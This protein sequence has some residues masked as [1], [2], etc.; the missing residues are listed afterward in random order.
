MSARIRI[1]VGFDGSADSWA[2]ARFA[3]A[4]AAA[5]HGTVRLVHSLLDRV[6]YAT[7]LPADLPPDLTADG[8]AEAQRLLE[9]ARTELA[10]ACPDTDV[11]TTLV[12]R[13]PG[14]ALVRVSRSAD[15][16]VLGRHGHGRAPVG[17]GFQRVHAGAVATHVMAYASCP[18]VVTT[19][20]DAET[21]RHPVV[22]GLDAAAPSA[23]AIAYAFETAA[24]R[25]T[26]LRVCYINAGARLGLRAGPRDDSQDDADARLLL[27]QA[28]AGWRAAFADVPVALDVLHGLDPAARLLDAAATASL[29]VVGARERAGVPRPGPGGVPDTLVRNAPCP[30]AVVRT[31]RQPATHP[32]AVG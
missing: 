32:A 22:L 15:L 21:A 18:V 26:S 25:G 9:L 20:V 11:Q 8:Q 12:L 28:L 5:G 10:Q 31:Q 13:A 24:R 30:V 17:G 29:V 4:E 23:S 2:A 1:V 19:A 16:I 14:A 6:A 3:A 7:L 27:S